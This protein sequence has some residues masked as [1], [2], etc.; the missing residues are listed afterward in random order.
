MPVYLFNLEKIKKI[1][2]LENFP[3]YRKPKITKNIND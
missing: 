1:E 2:A 3:N